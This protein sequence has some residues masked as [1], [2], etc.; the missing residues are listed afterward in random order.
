MQQENTLKETLQKQSEKASAIR[1]K[2]AK[3]LAEKIREQLVDLNF[4][5]VRFEMK[6][7]QKETF[8]ADGFDEVEFV[9]ATNPGEPLKPLGSVASGGE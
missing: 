4:L 1:K 2:Y 3:E 7:E 5:D 9:I 8:G 6:F